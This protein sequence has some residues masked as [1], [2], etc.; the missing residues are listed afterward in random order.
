[1][2]SLILWIVSS[3]FVIPS[4]TKNTS[5][6]VIAAL[7]IVCGYGFSFV[8]DAICIEN[9]YKNLFIVS[10]V[11]WCMY[12][13]LYVYFSIDDTESN[14]NP[15]EK[16]N[17]EYSQI[18]FKSILISSQINLSLFMLKPIFSQI[19]RKIRSCIHNKKNTSQR[20][21]DDAS[22]VQASYILYKRPYIH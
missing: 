16:Y 11:S 20:N 5:Y 2:Y 7:A 22:F 13:V 10:G 3:Y 14:W 21:T 1:M 9:K 12:H 4:F 19:S 8:F 6:Y 15:F 18:S 17:F